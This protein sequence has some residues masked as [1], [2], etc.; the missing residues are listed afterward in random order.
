MQR[1][2]ILNYWHSSLEGSADSSLAS[3]FVCSERIISSYVN[4]RTL[5]LSVVARIN[6]DVEVNLHVSPTLTPQPKF[7]MM[8]SHLAHFRWKVIILFRTLNDR[9]MCNKCSVPYN[10]KPI[11]VSASRCRS[12]FCPPGQYLLVDSV[13]HGQN[14]LAD[15]VPQQYMEGKEY[16]TLIYK[17]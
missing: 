5:N 16:T 11:N 6:Y 4:T 14:P 1:K 2:N 8:S 3:L 10:N 7:P 12:R 13:P 15:I 9:A 17:L